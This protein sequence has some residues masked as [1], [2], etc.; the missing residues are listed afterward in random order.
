MEL[1]PATPHDT[2]PTK[3]CVDFDGARGCIAKAR[4]VAVALLRHHAPHV[5]HTFHDDV[6]LVVSELV[7]N[8]VRHAPGPITLELALLPD[9][10]EISVGDSSPGLPYSRTPDRT[11]GRGWPIVRGLARRVRVVP[12]RDGKT[13]HAELAWQPDAV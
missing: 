9:G 1:P 13:V 2:Q 12:R 4:D 3:V 11:G 8:A 7:T 10:I 6:L 5:G